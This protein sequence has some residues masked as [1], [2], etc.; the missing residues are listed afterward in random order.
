MPSVINP[1]G[2]K[3]VYAPDAL[4]CITHL[5]DAINGVTLFG[6]DAN[7]HLLTVT[8]ANGQQ[9]VYT[10]NNMNRT[11]SRKDLMLQIEGYA[12]DNNGNLKSVTQRYALRFRAKS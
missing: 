2:Q 4:D 1:L 11:E 6:Y 5:T 10:P 8:D 9:T 3:M 7:S 12:Y